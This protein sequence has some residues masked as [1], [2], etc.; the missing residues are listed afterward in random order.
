VTVL[1]IIYLVSFGFAC[2]TVS[3]ASSDAAGAAA[4]LT[5]LLG[6]ALAVVALA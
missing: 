5:G 1:A 4:V 3:T 2:V 6:V